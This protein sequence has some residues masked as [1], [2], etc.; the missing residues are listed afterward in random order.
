MVDQP[1][2][3][4]T[5][6]DNGVA[7]ISTN[8]DPLNRMTLEYID[9]LEGAIEDIAA[10]NNIRAFVI[11]ADGLTNFSVGMNLKQIGAGVEAAGNRDAFFDQRLRIIRRIETMEK[12]SVATLF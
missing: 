9:E 6:Q 4:F 12:P 11:M 3:H 10:D 7:V 5:K 8:D 2:F 1:P